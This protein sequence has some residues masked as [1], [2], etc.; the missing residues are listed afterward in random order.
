MLKRKDGKQFNY[1]AQVP[2]NYDIKVAINI[3]IQIS[4]SPTSIHSGPT[5]KASN[6]NATTSS[7]LAVSKGFIASHF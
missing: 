6:K 5:L 4:V 1:K 2:P 3:N 7:D